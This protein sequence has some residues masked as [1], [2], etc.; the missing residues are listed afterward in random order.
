MLGANLTFASTKIVAVE[1]S[2][3]GIALLIIIISY[4]NGFALTG[5]TYPK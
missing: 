2:E 1:L 3:A 4:A 5:V